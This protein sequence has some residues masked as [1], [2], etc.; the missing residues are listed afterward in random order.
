MDLFILINVVREAR[1]LQSP[2]SR[3]NL[4]KKMRQ[5]KRWLRGEERQNMYVY[6]KQCAAYGMEGERKQRSLLE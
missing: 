4:C 5:V 6:I 2:Q 1:K 3:M